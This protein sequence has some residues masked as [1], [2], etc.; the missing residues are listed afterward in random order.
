MKTLTVHNH[1]DV[2][3]H[4]FFLILFLGMRLWKG[5]L[6]LFAVKQTITKV[7]ALNNNNHLFSS[8]ICK[9]CRAIWTAHLS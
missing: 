2:Y 5:R 8:E 6:Q 9:L 7:G 1:F 3:H 4:N